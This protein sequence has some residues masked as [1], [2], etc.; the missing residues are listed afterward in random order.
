MIWIYAAAGFFPWSIIGGN[1]LLTRG[2]NLPSMLCDEDGWMSYWLIS[3]LAPL[4]FFTFASNI[5]Y[6][7]VFP[8]LPAFA[9][10]F[11]EVWRRSNSSLNNSRWIIYLSLICGLSFL[12]V[13]LTFELKPEW[14]A[15]TQ[16]PVIQSWMSQDPRVGSNLIYWGNNIDYSGQFY[17]AGK[18]R[19]TQNVVELC[20]LLSNHLDNYLVINSKAIEEIPKVLYSKFTLV[21]TIMAKDEQVFLVHCPVMDC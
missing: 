1:W 13:T 15:K 4:V 7:Y 3:M 16:K 11:T 20:K 21:K 19:A 18:A 9:L 5:I 10:F 14:I 8:C 17:S 12:A 2:K 6:P